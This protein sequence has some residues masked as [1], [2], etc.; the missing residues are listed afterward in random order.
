M[1]SAMAC[2]AAV[3]MMVAGG[4]RKGRAVKREK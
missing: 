3:A 2:L 4:A 1:K